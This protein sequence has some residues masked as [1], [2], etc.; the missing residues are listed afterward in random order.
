MSVVIRKG[1]IAED[2]LNVGQGTFSR[3]TSTGST[4]TLE[5]VN[6]TS[7]LGG[8]IAITAAD[9]TPS[10]ADGTVFTCA[11]SGAVSITG[12]DDG[13]AG[14]RISI[15]FADSNTTIVDS[16]SIQLS[17]GSN[18]VSSANDVLTLVLAGSVWYEIGRSTN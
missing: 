1:L 5:K 10:V 2:D 4:Q 7:I 18:F 14:Q 17:G 16:A 15:I 11:N 3:G 12:F 9:T 6:E 8:V 13:T